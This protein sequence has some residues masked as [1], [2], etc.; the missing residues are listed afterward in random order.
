[1]REGAMRGVIKRIPVDRETG[2]RRGFL[3]IRPDGAEVDV[4]GHASAFQATSPKRF[5]DVREGDRV[6]YT[7]IEGDRGPKAIEIRTL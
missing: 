6:E 2:A 4:F 1:M 5:D 3:F 7:E